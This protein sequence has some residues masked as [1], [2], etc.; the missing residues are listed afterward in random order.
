MEK[1]IVEIYLT[2]NKLCDSIVNRVISVAEFL[3][4][5]VESGSVF[6]V[7]KNSTCKFA[8]NCTLTAD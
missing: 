7:Y 5:I 8:L 3:N 4:C 1:K 6:A 2:T